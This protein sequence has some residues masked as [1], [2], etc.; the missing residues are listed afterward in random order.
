MSE[1]T[2]FILAI[3]F[4]L[5]VYI[6]SRF[7]VVW[8]MRRT[9]AFIIQDLKSSAAFDSDSAVE[10]VY[11]KSNLFRVG[12]RNYKSKALGTMLQGGVVRKTA[13]GNFYLHEKN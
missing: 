13:D 12:M 9:C 1:T 2:Q 8:R 7:Y 6:L 10:L 4:L 3:I 11:A 5:G